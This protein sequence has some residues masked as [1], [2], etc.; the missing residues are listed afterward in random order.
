MRT[1][2]KHPPLLKTLLKFFGVFLFCFISFPLFGQ[3][4][5]REIMGTITNPNGEL[6]PG[7]NILVKGTTQGTVSNAN[8][9]YEIKINKKAVLIFSMVGYAPTEIETKD[10]DK[11]VIDIVLKSKVKGLEKMVVVG[12]SKVRQE[13]IASAVAEVNMDKV[14]TKSITKMEQAFRGTVP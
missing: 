5:E 13:H 2:F 4:Q 7:V 9:Q 12:Y 3:N 6:L 1:T 10:Y 8:G 14:R 11:D